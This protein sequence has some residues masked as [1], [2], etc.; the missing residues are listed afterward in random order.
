[1]GPVNRKKMDDRIKG[2]KRAAEEVEMSPLVQA[3]AEKIH[4]MSN[5]GPTK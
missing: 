2:I 1:M 4:S 3:A 5:G